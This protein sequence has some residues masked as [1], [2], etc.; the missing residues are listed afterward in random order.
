[1][2][3]VFLFEENIAF[4]RRTSQKSATAGNDAD[5][6]MAVDDNA[7]TCTHTRPGS[8]CWWSVTLDNDVTVN[9][10]SILTGKKCFINHKLKYRLKSFRRY[11]PHRTAWIYRLNSV[12]LYNNDW[13][14]CGI[15]YI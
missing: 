15:C 14:L 5:G 8:P 1:M 12:Y 13:E 7:D 3:N 9:S 10:V 4:R 6:A 11:H 2:S